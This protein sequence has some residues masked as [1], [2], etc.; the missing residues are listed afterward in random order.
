MPGDKRFNPLSIHPF[1][2]QTSLQQSR[3]YST[4]ELVAAMELLLEANLSLVSRG[5]DE[6]LVLQQTLVRIAQ[7]AQ[8]AGAI[9]T[10]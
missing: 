9:Q 8:N 6:A 1:V 10:K 3:K 7:A 4:A 2:L 5:L